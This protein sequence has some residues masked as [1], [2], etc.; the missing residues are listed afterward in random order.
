MPREDRE[1]IICLNQADMRDGF[2]VFG[3]SEAT[4]FRRLCR[5]IGGQDNLHNLKVS[6]FEGKPVWWECEVPVEYMSRTTWGIRKRKGR[7][8]PTSTPASKNRAERP[9]S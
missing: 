4:H 7:K 3:T 9:V 8:P 1:T 5:R 6:K 2:F